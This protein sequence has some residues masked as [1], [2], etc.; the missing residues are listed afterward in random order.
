MSQ[1]LSIGFQTSR[2]SYFLFASKLLPF[3]QEISCGKYKVLPA[4][5][6]ADLV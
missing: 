3:E 6:K 5:S 4:D 2:I 1:I